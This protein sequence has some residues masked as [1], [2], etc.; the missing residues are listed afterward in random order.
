MQP[1]INVGFS[2]S[3][4]KGTAMVATSYSWGAFG[5]KGMARTSIAP[6]SAALVE[7][8]PIVDSGSSTLDNLRPYVACCYMMEALG[9]IY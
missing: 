6:Q 5:T 4:A 1:P 8:Q 7:M 9:M 2:F 3:D